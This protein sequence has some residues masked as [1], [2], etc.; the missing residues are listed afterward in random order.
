[1][2]K[3]PGNPFWDHE[4]DVPITL[5]TQADWDE[6]EAG[7]FITADHVLDRFGRML[8]HALGNGNPN[9]A[10]DEEGFFISLVA[11]GIKQDGITL[12][13]NTDDHNPPHCHVLVKGEPGKKLRIDLSTGEFMDDVPKKI[14]PQKKRIKAM[15][16]K[17]QDALSEIWAGYQD[18]TGS[19]EDDAGAV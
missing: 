6:A 16:A 4:Q 3:H 9:A 7:G 11:K 17:N 15:F 19:S 5:F 14:Q 12:T 13:V 1:M 10:F 2:S 18:D 8:E